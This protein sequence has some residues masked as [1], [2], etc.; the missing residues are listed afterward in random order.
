MEETKKS[1]PTLR[2]RANKIKNARCKNLIAV[3]ENPDCIPF[4]VA[5]TS[6]L[7]FTLLASKPE[8]RLVK[9]FL[10]PGYKPDKI[11]VIGDM[12]YVLCATKYSDLK[13]NNNFIERKLNVSA[14]TRVYNT[15]AKLVEL[16][17]TPPNN[18]FKPNPLRGSA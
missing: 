10:A 5:D 6:K 7:Y 4:K 15:I 17:S 3:I 9:E 11:E 16:C 14:T 18:S 2:A 12:T 8:I 13:I 1:K